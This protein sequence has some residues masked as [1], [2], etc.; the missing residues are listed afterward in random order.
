MIILALITIGLPCIAAYMIV[1]AYKD[2]K[3]LSDEI[4]Q[5]K[6]KLKLMKNTGWGL[7]ILSITNLSPYLVRIEGMV[8]L[9]I[10]GPLFL[11]GAVILYLYYMPKIDETLAVAEKTD[12]IL[13]QVVLMRALGLSMG[14]TKK[15]LT[16]LM[17]EKLV[18]VLNPD[19]EDLVELIF[20][21][22]TFS[23]RVKPKAARESP[24]QETDEDTR[25][26]HQDIVDLGVDKINEMILR[27]SLNLGP[28]GRPV[29]NL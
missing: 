23:G 21:V 2:T 10:S 1:S 16:K 7:I 26:N 3:K 8:F 22:R 17:K 28:S 29:R 18:L 13:T 9:G 20:L 24:G 15:T 25:N 12:G 5:I 11:L 4:Q 14:I 19:E 6:A 27:N